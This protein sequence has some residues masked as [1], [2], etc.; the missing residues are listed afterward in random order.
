MFIAESGSGLFL[1]GVFL[2]V[3]TVTSVKLV[4]FRSNRWVNVVIAVILV[5][6]KLSLLTLLLNNGC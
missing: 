3:V 1:T 4:I 5:V 2:L 6:W